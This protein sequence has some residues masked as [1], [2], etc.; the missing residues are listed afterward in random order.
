MKLFPLLEC[1]SEDKAFVISSFFNC[2][3]VFTGN[4]KPYLVIGTEENLKTFEE[5]VLETEV[6]KQHQQ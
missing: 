4:P 2:H 6:I 3:Y 1:D 5:F